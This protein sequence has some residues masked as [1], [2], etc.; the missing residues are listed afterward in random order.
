M[1]IDKIMEKMELVLLREEQVSLKEATAQ[2]I[3]NALGKVVMDAIAQD[4]YESRHAHERVREAYYFSAEYLIGRMVY[5]N[6]FSLGILDDVKKEFGKKGLDFAMFEEIEDAALG[7]GGL[8][9]LAACYLDSAATMNLPLTG[10]GLR[11][12]YGLFK[13]S[14]D[15]G[16]QVENADDWQKDGDP[17]SR[18]RST[19][20]VLVQFADQT[21]RAVPY[22]MPIIGYETQNVGTLRL[23]QSEPVKEFD[24]RLFNDQEYALAV[25]EK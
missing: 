16:F 21:V 22:D 11:Y 18:R 4:W 8:G 9:R 13:Q 10:Y 2:Q 17:W 6:L 3:H 14:F 5:N 24:F 7:N 20:E 1:H 15:D 19:H 25:L 23:W 12:K